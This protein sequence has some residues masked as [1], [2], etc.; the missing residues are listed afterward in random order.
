MNEYFIEY[1]KKQIC[2]C[3][4]G[5]NGY[6]NLKINHNGNVYLFVEFLYM[7]KGLFHAF[8]RVLKLKDK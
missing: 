6:V 2:V 1:L 7:N 3:F 5:K 4:D 8:K